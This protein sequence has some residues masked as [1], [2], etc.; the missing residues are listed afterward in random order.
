MNG[1]HEVTGSTPVWSTNLRSLMSAK[2]AHH[3]VTV[4]PCERE[5]LAQFLGMT[6]VRYDINRALEEERLV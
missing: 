5:L 6:I 4:D 1:I 3:G 2:V